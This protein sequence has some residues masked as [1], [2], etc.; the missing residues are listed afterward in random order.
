MSLNL[1]LHEGPNGPQVD[2]YQTPTCITFSCLSYDPL[3]NEPDG[4]QEGVRKRY[5]LWLRSRYEQETLMEHERKIL[6]VKDP[7]FSY[8]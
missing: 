4:G 1:T 7:Y 2:L 6:L 8:V 5:L 3:T